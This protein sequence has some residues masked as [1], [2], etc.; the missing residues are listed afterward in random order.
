MTDAAKEAGVCHSTP[1]AHRKRDAHFAKGWINAE[2]ASPGP[3]HTKRKK[4][5][6][7]E[8]KTDF[9]EA[10]AET[11]N[12]SAAAFKAGTDPSTAYSLRRSDAEFAARWLDALLEGFQHLELEVLGFLRD[13]DPAHKMDVGSS[14]RL[15]AV[16]RETVAKERARRTQRSEES[17]LNTLNERIERLKQQ[18]ERAKQTAME[19]GADAQ[20]SN[21]QD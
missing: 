19:D 9:L 7:P 4:R 5:H 13:P 17:I 2:A 12:V 6:N 15:L 18:D 10:L 16:H 14:L 8:W 20:D 21:E 3:A 11:S 1:Y